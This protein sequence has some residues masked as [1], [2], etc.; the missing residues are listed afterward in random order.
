MLKFIVLNDEI[1]IPVSTNIPIVLSPSSPVFSKTPTKTQIPST[2]MTYIQHQVD[3]LRQEI[4]KNAAENNELKN[5]IKKNWGKDS[6]K[7]RRRNTLWK[8]GSK[9]EVKNQQAVIEMLITG[10]KCRNEWKVVK[11]DKR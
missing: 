4:E 6:Q 5:L 3:A 10:D 7:R 1:L 8:W 9:N 2:N 11:N